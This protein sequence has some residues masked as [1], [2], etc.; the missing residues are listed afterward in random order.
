MN[1]MQ[2]TADFS[3]QAAAGDAPA[4]PTFDL[5]AY[6]GAAIRQSWSRNPL[7]VDLAGMDTSR[8]SIP[9]LWGHDASLDSV[10]GQSTSVTSD[11]QQLTLAGEL[12]GEGPVAERVVS[13]A[14]KG[15]RFQASIGADTGRIEN[16]APGV[17]FPSGWWPSW[18]WLVACGA[19]HGGTSDR[20]V[21]LKRC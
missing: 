12:I 18:S 11:G 4:T 17:A 3:L 20:C 16:V 2:L 9:I 6:T 5:V 8:Q 1:Q 7:V 19:S 13:L 14:K 21:R 15:L 10:L